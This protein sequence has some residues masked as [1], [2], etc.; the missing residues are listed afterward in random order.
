M[1]EYF[2]VNI[3]ELCTEL[4]HERMMK[5]LEISSTEEAFILHSKE[6]KTIFDKWYDYYYNKINEN[7]YL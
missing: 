5:E 7:Q 4:A 6:N 2:K 1:S 3:Q